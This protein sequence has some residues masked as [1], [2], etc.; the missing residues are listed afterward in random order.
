V[1]RQSRGC[2]QSDHQPVRLD[3]PAVR[4][5]HLVSRHPLFVI[6]ICIGGI[7]ES[8][9]YHTHSPARCVL[10]K[11]VLC[12]V[13]TVMPVSHRFCYPPSHPRTVVRGHCISILVYEGLHC[14]MCMYI[15][16]RIFT[17]PNR[18]SDGSEL[19]SR[20]ASRFPAILAAIFPGA[21]QLD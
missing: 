15:I 10:Y 12:G 18:V 20:K 3:G 11:C 16:G 14:I 2:L 17:A 9:L 5:A 6:C 21:N 19:F 8:A 7:C 4:R 1:H 13:L